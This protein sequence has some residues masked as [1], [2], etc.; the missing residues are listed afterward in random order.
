LADAATDVGAR[1]SAPGRIA[2]NQRRFAG[3]IL[4]V[5]RRLDVIRAR[6]DERT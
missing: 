5:A 3:S 1:T 4:V 2:W 6:V